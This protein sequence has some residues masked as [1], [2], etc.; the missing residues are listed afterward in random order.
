MKETKKGLDSLKWKSAL[1]WWWNWKRMLEPQR[2]WCFLTFCVYI[3]CIFLLTFGVIYAINLFNVI[4][5]TVFGYTLISRK[6]LVKF[7]ENI[8]KKQFATISGKNYLSCQIFIE[9]IHLDF[10][11][12]RENKET[13]ISANHVPTVLLIFFP[14]LNIH[15]TLTATQTAGI[16]CR[17]KCG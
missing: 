10:R 17:Q 7:T 15:H 1:P 4:C 6:I 9:S 14:F 12:Q 3:V 2:F 13:L 11:F 8:T 5:I 16:K